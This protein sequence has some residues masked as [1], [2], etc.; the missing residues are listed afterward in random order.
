MISLRLRPSTLGC[1]AVLGSLALAAPVSAEAPAAATRP[2][3]KNFK[4][5]IYCRVDDVR[6][7]SEPG[8]LDANF[9]QLSKYLKID[10]VYLETH[11]SQVVNDRATM[12]RAKEFFE[13]HGIRTAG[14]ITTVS[15]EG[16]EFSSFCYTNPRHRQKVKDMVTFTA[17]LFD[18]VI[19]DDFFFTSCKCASC[20]KA[21][22]ARS[23]TQF[24]LELMKEVSENLVV[25]PAKAVNP[26]VQVVIKYP[27]WYE[28]YQ[29]TGYNLEAEPRLFDRLYTGTETRDAVYTDQH[30][31]E[32]QSYSI[33]RYLENVAPGRNGGGWVDPY[34]RGTLDRYAEQLALTLLSK[35]RELTL[36]CFSELLNPIRQADGSSTPGSMVAPVAGDVLERVDALLG[37]LGR[38]LGVTSYKPYHS[39][40]EDYLH[41]YLGNIGIP[42]ELTPELGERGGVE[43]LSVSL[44]LFLA[45]SARFDP[46]L[47]EKMKK[48]LVA[49]QT[50][51]ITSGLLRALQGKGIEDI[52]ELEAT[53]QKVYSSRFFDGRNVFEAARSI[54]LPQ[55]RYGT[56]DS[57]EDLT[58]LDGTNGYPVLHHADYGEGR[59]VVLT[60]PDNMSALYDLPAPALNRIRAV[61]TRGLPVRLAGP[62]RVALFVYD[63]QTFVLNS[64]LDHNTSMDVIVDGAG[65]T[66]T[67]LAS[68][69]TRPGTTET[70]FDR[71]QTTRFTVDLLPHMLRAYRWRQDAASGPSAAAFAV[72]K[73]LGRGVNIIGYDPLWDDRAKGRFQEKHFRLIKDAGFSSV[74]INLHPFKHM[75]A[76]NGYRLAD[77]WLAVLDWAVE[78]AR[79]A[80]L[81]VLL[82]LHEFGAMA[83]DPLGRKELLLAFWRQ[84]GE[85][86]KDLP[87]DVVF[88]LLNE[89]YGK[90]TPE[91][92]NAYL[93]EGLATIRATNPK[94]VVVIGPA[95]YNGID[96]LG[97]LQL[98]ED[99]R[100]LIVTVHY[101]TPMEFT[102]QGAPWAREYK[103]LSGVTWSGTDQER[104]RVELDFARAREW[105]VSHERPILLGEFGAYDAAPMDS[106]ARYTAHVART[107]EA[108]GWSWAYW[109]FDS[110]FI[111]YDIEKDRWV[112]PL[113][114]ALIP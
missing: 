85:R 3:Y 44:P 113:I 42:I 107:A 5:A 56:N 19:L 31:Q 7:M 71:K 98:P 48:R 22:G 105:A 29:M 72:N 94:R 53:D 15:D 108:N 25:G 41:S 6:R 33:M 23:W 102:H 1:I 69:M 2:H 88:E 36:F 9:G 77:S 20:I 34:A 51:V 64:F 65:V 13:S 16:H 46:A 10:K 45:E 59:L 100:N 28:H 89:P 90:L 75:D 103:D 14:G 67:D 99:D 32:Y 54:L 61:V 70:G 30:L 78:N 104:R 101:Y 95:H 49:G 26:K 76:A 73:K 92:W 12:L 39:S 40:G 17:G 110:D 50:V 84:V 47:V 38:P 87:D 66:L 106:R 112:E 4:L 80:G 63:N 68:G 21:K 97:E 8:W 62:S 109:Q 86:Y 11:R 93:K 83:E 27:N 82:D 43:P 91:L 57:W 18:E 55:I 81:T 74:R 111:V 52:V 35:A 79:R 58:A 60:I 37:S 96:H 24:R 114:S